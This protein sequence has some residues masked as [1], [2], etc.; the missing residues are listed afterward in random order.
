MRHGKT[1][2]AMATAAALMMAAG[3]GVSGGEAT[4][5]DRTEPSA[6]QSDS[7]MLIVYYSYSG[8]TRRVAQRLSDLTGG[9]LAELALAEP[10]TSDPYDVSNR[11]FAERDTGRMPELAAPVPNP[12]DY[13]LVLVG[14]PVWNDSVAN[15]VLSW[16]Q[17]TDLTGKIVAPFWTYITSEG[18]TLQDFEQAIQGGDVAEGLGL[19]GSWSNI[20]DT[21]RGWLA[22]LRQASTA[23]SGR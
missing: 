18:T 15:P 7:S 22:D 12:S 14:T 2:T 10:Y 4:N 11:V 1:L 17:R 20:D 16:L 19:R 6:H 5:T 21:L 13:D 8:T 9:V 23:R 3:C